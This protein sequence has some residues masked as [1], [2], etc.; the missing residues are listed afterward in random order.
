MTKEEI[1]GALA[2][3]YTHPQT[4]HEVLN[5]ELIE[6]MFDELSPF[7]LN[8]DAE[9][10]RLKEKLRHAYGEDKLD[11]FPTADQADMALN[12]L[13]KALKGEPHD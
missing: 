8:K 2:R 9:I 4:E 13:S 6:A 7:I 12:N 1:L 3:G 10:A 11:G 5:P